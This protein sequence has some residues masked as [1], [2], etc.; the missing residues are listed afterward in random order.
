MLGPISE[1]SIVRNLLEEE[2][3]EKN[4]LKERFASLLD[5]LEVECDVS[6]DRSWSKQYRCSLH[7]TYFRSDTE[8]DVCPVHDFAQKIKKAY[9]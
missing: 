7:G 4:L 9:E 1:L 8:T 6:A 2:T 5:E 3:R